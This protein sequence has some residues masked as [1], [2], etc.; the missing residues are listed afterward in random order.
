MK[1]GEENLVCK[2][3]SV[4]RSS[5]PGAAMWHWMLTSSRWGLKLTADPCIYISGTGGEVFH[6]G[7]YVGDI[8][9]ARK[10]DDVIKCIKEE[11]SSKFNIKAIG[12]LKYFRDPRRRTDL[13]GT[14]SVATHRSC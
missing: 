12:K 13:D 7:V 14:T 5:F 3:V 8:L 9:L 4:D 10:N 1:E 2:R 11:L 6:I